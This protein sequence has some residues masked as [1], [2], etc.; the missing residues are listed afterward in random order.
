MA[1]IAAHGAASSLDDD[2]HA[3]PICRET[4]VDAFSTLCGHTFC[5]A[6][7]NRHLEHGSTCPCCSQP[8]SSDSLFPNLALDKLLRDLSRS[9]Q[10]P[11][12]GVS[13]PRDGA[14]SPAGFGFA[15][16][17][18]RTRASELADAL[19]D[20]PLE[21]LT[22]LLRVIADKHKRLV[23]DDKQVS[24]HVLRDFLALSHRR[25]NEAVDAL[26]RE[27]G[28]IDDD[29]EWVE[30]Q[31]AELGGSRALDAFA[32]EASLETDPRELARRRALGGGADGRAG[33]NQT[34][35]AESDAR[36]AV[37]ANHAAT[38][39][40]EMLSAW[41]IDSRG[42]AGSAAAR[43]QSRR[44]SREDRR[45]SLGDAAPGSKRS[46]MD[47][48]RGA[49]PSKPGAS[50]KESPEELRRTPSKDSGGSSSGSGDRE[51]DADGASTPRGN[52]GSDLLQTGSPQKQARG[53]PPPRMD[54]A[55]ARAHLDRAALSVEKR[56]AIVRHFA[57][58][59]RLYSEI[60]GKTHGGFKRDGSSSTSRPSVSSRKS[61]RDDLERFGKVVD[62]FAS[63]NRLRVVGELRHADVLSSSPSASIVSS[64]EFDNERR[65]FA[66][67]GVSKRI[68][69]F[70]FR[71]VCSRFCPS[72]SADREQTDGDRLATHAITTRS[73]LSCLSY[74][75]FLTNRVAS[76]DYEGV[77]AVWD[78]ETR[79][80]V[81][82]FEEHDKR[83]WTVDFCRADAKLLASG[84]DDGRVKIWSTDA[85]ASVLEL[86]VRA[87]V[88]CARFGPNDA[89]KLAVGCADHRVHLFD[90]RYP[91]E[92][93]AVLSGHRKATSYVRFLS[94]GNEL[95]SASTDST[96]CVWDVRLNAVKKAAGRLGKRTG[97]QSGPLL[98]S[99]PARVLEGHVN[100]KNFVGLS[101]GGGDLIAC[102]SETN[103]VFVYHKSFD[104]P[105]VKYGFDD[106]SERGGGGGG[107][108][109]GAGRGG[110]RGGRGGGD[111]DS[112]GPSMP[113]HFISATCW[114]GEEDILL[115]ANS[116]GS[117]KAL[118]LVE[119]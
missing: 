52:G 5:F 24:M 17:S 88:C 91:Q 7:I 118:Q 83:A 113:A 60:R 107:G 36:N 19:T 114:R 35:P 25:K 23:M 82:E 34:S 85:E 116:S 112:G 97:K 104:R 72:G 70:D 76:S 11:G 99:Q 95:V 65:V 27:I 90:L 21:Q 61:A 20:L 81:C 87:N 75:A 38:M 12:A 84:S 73:K 115:V 103:E 29:L 80:A 89:Y 2:A 98:V 101:V 31:V 102:G 69:F 13:S 15:G 63:K 32:Q 66:T 26:E 4:F 93:V 96:M 41:G 42:G 92:A 37:A 94:S 108:G 8:L 46:S 22:P 67:A 30:R 117:I 58:V 28:C 54:P 39:V 9:G 106:E 62:A 74:N 59:Q 55:E 50:G 16:A 1:A 45:G 10:I 57:G 43:G 105:M 6:C 119:A 53:A 100:E 71:D 47:M 14:G 86:D 18:A 51:R 109:G 56:D 110:G 44:A 49:G 3:C 78:A 77:V 111:D 40:C 68:Q 64:I 48:M 79:L 33:Q